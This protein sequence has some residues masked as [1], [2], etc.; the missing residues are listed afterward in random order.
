MILKTKIEYL[1][2]DLSKLSDADREKYKAKKEYLGDNFP[3]N[4]KIKTVVKKDAIIDM[5]NNLLYVDFGEG[6]I[7]VKPLF[8]ADLITYEDGSASYFYPSVSFEGNLDE[9]YQKLIKN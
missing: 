5:G 7:Q 4:E 6:M 1:E 8:S 9:I 2:E 3:E